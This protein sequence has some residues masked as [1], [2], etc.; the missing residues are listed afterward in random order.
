MSTVGKRNILVALGVTLA[1]GTTLCLLSPRS[2]YPELFQGAAVQSSEAGDLRWGYSVEQYLGA[3]PSAKGV[4]LS[5][6]H[7]LPFK[8]EYLTFDS[9]GTLYAGGHNSLFA[10]HPSQGTLEELPLP[11][12]PA[13][14]SYRSLVAGLDGRLYGTPVGADQL[15]VYDP[16]TGKSRLL[17]FPLGSEQSIWL[18]IAKPDGLI[19]GIGGAPSYPFVA[20]DPSSNT[21]TPLDIASPGWADDRWLLD[22]LEGGDGLLYDVIRRYDKASGEYHSV[23]IA[24]DLVSRTTITREVSM[25]VYT[26]APQP[27]GGVYLK[28]A[29]EILTYTSA[30]KELTELPL[31][32]GVEPFQ[33]IALTAQQDGQ[34]YGVGQRKSSSPFLFAYHLPL[35][36]FEEIG[37]LLDG[38]EPQ[39]MITGPDNRVYYLN[40]KGQAMILEPKLYAPS[41]TV[42]SG[43]IWP[44]ALVLT[45]TVVGDYS[46]SVQDL[47][48]AIDGQVYGVLSNSRENWLFWY[49]PQAPGAKVSRVTPAV[50][51]EGWSFL[52][53]TAIV[54]LEDGRVVG[55]T[56]S[57]RLFIYNPATGE[58]WDVGR[59]VSDTLQIAALALGRNG[60]VYGGTS[61]HHKRAT[62]F[63]FDP[64]TGVITDVGTPLPQASLV[65]ALTVAQDGRV[66]AGVDCALV[67]YDPST[68]RTTRADSEEK[69][70]HPCPLRA[71]ATGAN[72]SIYIGY[73]SHLFAYNLLTASMSD[74][75]KTSGNIVGLTVGNDGRIYGN[76]HNEPAGRGGFLTN[77]IFVY[78]PAAKRITNLGTA[79]RT[80]VTLVTCGDGTIYGGSNTT[81]SNY[82]DHATL[83]SFR[84]DC[85]SGP[86]GVW[87]KITWEADTPPGT[88]VAVDVLD[89]QGKVLLRDVRNG[90]S[91]WA[92]KA[93]SN[94]SVILRATLSTRDGRVTPV[95]KRWRV[96]Y[97]FRCKE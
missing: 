51:T 92:I 12:P 70:G 21:A 74:L 65:G 76:I 50:S 91:L 67:M 55:G 95:L 88:S 6:L 46:A 80:P 72:G 56:N 22:P 19:Y 59:P 14:V 30:D 25:A 32:A 53:G 69:D 45:R 10:Y 63:A 84:T 34:L 33:P 18:W 43:P 97:T 9:Q 82:I 96:D 37:W 7:P 31:P 1:L 93:A 48:C 41:G 77:Y 60:L 39:Q 61:S 81:D 85:P 73:G 44:K 36:P 27:G 75:G 64:A 29:A 87:D 52:G 2:P 15:F 58:T 11:C 23:I 40:R 83:F 38:E 57:G 20:Y 13:S 3:S 8:A 35:G 24:L 68:G 54:A 47:A 79:S 94:P 49:D 90:D 42:Q 62:L 5:H 4:V 78:D 28:A 71:L 86:V 16:Q 17:G 26:L 66:Y 89:R